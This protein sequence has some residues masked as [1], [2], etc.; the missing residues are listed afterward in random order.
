MTA[1]DLRERA[2]K[3]RVI[4]GST[5]TPNQRAAFEIA[6]GECEVAAGVQEVVSA[7]AWVAEEI[8]DLTIAVCERIK[9]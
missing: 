5:M 4:A 7:V 8:R 2:E 6:A 1:K 9:R 3:L